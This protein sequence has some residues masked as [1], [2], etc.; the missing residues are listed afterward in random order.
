MKFIGIDLG[1]SFIKG[2]VLDPALLTLSHVARQPFPEPLPGL[3]AN[4][5]EIDPHAVVTA[6]EAV[7]AEL[8]SSAPDCQGILF[9]GQMG[10]VILAD[11]RGRP[12]TN[13]LSWRD[14]RTTTA[15]RSGTGSCLEV[16]SQRLAGDD[17]RKTGN[18][19]RA[20]SATSLLFWLAE[21]GSLPAGAVPLSLSDFVVMRLCAAPPFAEYTQA[22]G[23]LDLETLD[24][25]RGAFEKLGLAKLTWPELRAAWRPVG[26]LRAGPRAIPCYPAVGDH[27]CA[28]AGAL[29][30]DGELSLN[31]STGSQV[32]LLTREVL[33]GDYQTRPYLDARSLNT[34]TH[35]PAGRSLEVLVGLLTELAA[36]QGTAVKDPWSEIVRA[37]AAVGDSDLGV[38]L[39]FFAGPM[40]N[41][42]GIS[43]ISTENL[44][45]GHLFRAAFR[46]MAENY[47]VC[48]ARLS[49]GREWRRIVFSGGVAQKLELLRQF[50]Q[51]RIGGEARVCPNS[52]DTLL[53][54]LVVS[55]VVSERARD[56]EAA[57]RLVREAHES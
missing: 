44:T 35:L 1:S 10:G 40:G 6:V 7:V 15:Q 22:L 26:T 34:I 55:L 4:H 46:S 54:L 30:N 16:A 39:A 53:G 20:G 56:L 17:L 14:Q 2:A 13:Y 19:L 23:T 37:A 36:A 24:W 25:H 42:G 41:R 47:A 12:L 48:A 33:L 11:E 9:T 18:E 57:S 45:V 50:I 49:P 21:N 38:D 27:Q 3:P 32:S 31:V 52:E 29:L 51:E 28:L 8:L 5:F 43:Q